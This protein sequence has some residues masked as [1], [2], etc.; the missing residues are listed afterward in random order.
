MEIRVTNENFIEIAKKAVADHANE[1]KENQH[2][3]ISE[4]NVHLVWNSY[5]L[6]NMKAILTTTKRDGMYY[7]ITY[8]AQKNEVYFDAYK[9]TE[10]KK[11]GFE[12]QEES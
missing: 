6:G 8:N 9:K 10:N 4:K 2:A 3:A 11:L 5:I 7:E 12:H 1:N